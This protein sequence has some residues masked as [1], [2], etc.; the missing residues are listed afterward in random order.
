LNWVSLSKEKGCC[1]TQD[2][3]AKEK[4]VSFIV[5]CVNVRTI[6]FIERTE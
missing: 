5:K 2:D 1:Y 6:S 3:P 4:N